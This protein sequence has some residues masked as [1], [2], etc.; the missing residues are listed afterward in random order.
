MKAQTMWLRLAV[1]AFYLGLMASPTSSQ[2]GLI[3]S[4]GSQQDNRSFGGTVGTRFAVGGT[5]ILVQALGF[6]D[7]GA[8]GLTQSHQ[9]G[10][11]TDGGTLLAS[12]TVPA[13]LGGTYD[14]GWRY[15][16]IA[17]ILLTAGTTY[18]LGAETTAGDLFSD[19]DVGSGVPDFSYGSLIGDVNPTNV[20]S[21]S[22]F[23]FPNF[24]G[25]GTDLR[26]APANVSALVA[27]AAVPEPSMLALVAIAG[28]IGLGRRQRSR[29][30]AFQNPLG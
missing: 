3:L 4:D 12:V 27:A 14:D 16:S 8:D 19:A 22:A 1:A 9:V 30:D 20:F 29:A 6:E 24:N 25:G 23:S 18:V 21:F 5:N 15:V 2:A 17:P 26:W 28:L 13:G 7:P 11:W 10:L